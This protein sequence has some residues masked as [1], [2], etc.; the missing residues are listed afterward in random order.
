MQKRER[1][2]TVDDLLLQT[3][4]C[5]L[6][7]SHW[8]NLAQ[9]PKKQVVSCTT[10]GLYSVAKKKFCIEKGLTSW[11]KIELRYQPQKIAYCLY[12]VVL[13]LAT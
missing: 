12:L 1:E 7:L 11:S 6:F 10:M 3:V 8:V 2:C 4:G 13:L 5:K 9:I